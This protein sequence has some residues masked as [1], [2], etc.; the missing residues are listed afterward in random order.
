MGS[1]TRLTIDVHWGEVTF[2]ARR[3]KTT[4]QDADMIRRHT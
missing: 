2:I 4:D 1:V 3:N